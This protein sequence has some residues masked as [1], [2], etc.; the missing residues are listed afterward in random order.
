LQIGARPTSGDVDTIIFRRDPM[1]PNPSSP[2]HALAMGV[3]GQGFR[4]K[5][6]LA[7]NRAKRFPDRKS[8]IADAVGALTKLLA[9]ICAV[10]PKTVFNCDSTVTHPKIRMAA[11]MAKQA[12]ILAAILKLDRAILD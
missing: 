3:C 10:K 2:T 12:Q 11:R 7:G 1:T 5:C 9:A 8:R 4:R 6:A